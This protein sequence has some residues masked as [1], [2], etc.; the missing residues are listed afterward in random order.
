MSMTR[1][2]FNKYT[3][4]EKCWAWQRLTKAEKDACRDLSD[5]H[6]DLL[7]LEGW[8]VELVYVD[9][10]K[11]RGIVSRSTGWRP[12][13]I[14]LPRIDSSGGMGVSEKARF[15]ARKLRKVR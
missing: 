3:K 12:C 8:R 11:E 13:H 5:L 1:E 4:E 15:A 14:L 10:A 2:V 6:P 9:G 7:G